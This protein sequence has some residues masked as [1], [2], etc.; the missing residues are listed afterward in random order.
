MAG[1]S[2]SNAQ[3]NKDAINCKIYLSECSITREIN[4]ESSAP[5]SSQKQMQQYKGLGMKTSAIKLAVTSAV[6]LSLMACG[7]DVQVAQAKAAPVVSP[8]PS[9]PVV[10]HS[11]ENEWVLDASEDFDVLLKLGACGGSK[12]LDNPDKC[13]GS[14]SVLLRDKQSSDAFQ[15]ISLSNI[16]GYKGYSARNQSTGFGDGADYPLTVELGDFDADG[17]DDIAI[18]SGNQGGYGSP[19]YHVYL[20]DKKA[21]KM[22]FNKP[23]STLTVGASGMF[24]LDNGRIVSYSKSGCCEHYSSTYRFVNGALAPVERTSEVLSANDSNMM[25]VTK[26]KFA[27]GRWSKVSTEQRPAE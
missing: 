1:Q 17:H 7:K 10:N 16:E 6:V 3:C 19:S 4:N 15:T 9:K 26:E 13:S 5:N 12:N 27:N 23:L 22:V 18:W 8:E 25:T 11:S 24:E 2:F 20:F 14:G 21:N